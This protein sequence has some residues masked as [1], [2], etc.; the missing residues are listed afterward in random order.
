MSTP[1]LLTRTMWNLAYGLGKKVGGNHKRRTRDERQP[2]DRREMS[3]I[4]GD[5]WTIKGG[6]ETLAQ[7]RAVMKIIDLPFRSVSM[8]TIYHHPNWPIC[9][10]LP[11]R[12]NRGSSS[13]RKD[14]ALTTIQNESAQSIISMSKVLSSVCMIKCGES[15][16]TG[17]LVSIGE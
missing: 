6:L 7:E 15:G 8:L 4:F 10:Q 3:R 12:R 9:S 14:E 16:A 11:K 17:F 13:S 2:C 5:W 1:A